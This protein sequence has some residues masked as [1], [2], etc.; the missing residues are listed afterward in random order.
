MKD[1]AFQELLPLAIREQLPKR[2]T[3]NLAEAR[4]DNF[5]ES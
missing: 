4:P 1:A 5:L 3:V 2:S